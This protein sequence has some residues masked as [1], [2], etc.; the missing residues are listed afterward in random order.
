MISTK[1]LL[2]SIAA[3]HG[4]KLEVRKGS[5]LFSDIYLETEALLPQHEQ[6]EALKKVAAELEAAN[7]VYTIGRTNNPPKY[8]KSTGGY[9]QG[10]PRHGDPLITIPSVEWP[11]NLV[12]KKAA[13][14]KDESDKIPFSEE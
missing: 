2:Q 12:I 14:A 10:H 7:L 3:K 4:L 8:N 11:N 13:Q 9:D 5:S 1:E 6:A